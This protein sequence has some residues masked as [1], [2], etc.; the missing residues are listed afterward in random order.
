MPTYTLECK[1]EDCLRV[2][3]R[4]L[5]FAQYDEAK[6]GV[7]G[8]TCESCG[9]PAEF[10]FVPGA[11]G[12]NLKEGESGG[13]TTKSLKENGYRKSRRETM[14]KREKDHVFKSRL[15]PNYQGQEAGSWSDVKDH[16]R[17]VKGAEAA[18]TYDPFVKGS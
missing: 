9:C 17:T 13:W 11:I 16:V 12:F 7:L 6:K 4:R 18:S 3:E 15:V 1:D 2:Q 5:T 10:K 8:L 14:A